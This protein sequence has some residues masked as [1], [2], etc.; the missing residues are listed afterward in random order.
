M[1]G[2]V[3][4]TTTRKRIAVPMVRCPWFFSANGHND[5]DP[6]GLIHVDMGVVGVCES[7][8]H[9]WEL[10]GTT[11][12]SRIKYQLLCGSLVLAHDLRFLVL[13]GDVAKM[14]CLLMVNEGFIKTRLKQVGQSGGC[15]FKICVWGIVAGNRFDWH[16]VW[17]YINQ[18]QHDK[19]DIDLRRLHTCFSWLEML[20]WQIEVVHGTLS[21]AILYGLS[22]KPLGFLWF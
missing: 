5:D 14:W 15:W 4:I 2:K 18:V 20:L 7:L 17:K 16:G 21:R 6:L 9:P 1:K 3:E 13:Q 11:Y 22:S 12:S 19:N 10:A 8:K